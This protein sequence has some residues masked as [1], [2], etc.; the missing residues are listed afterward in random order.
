MS[1]GISTGKRRASGETTANA[2]AEEVTEELTSLPDVE[3]P[4]ERQTQWRTPGFSRMRMTWRPEDRVVI[5]QARQMV[6]G[7]VMRAFADLYRV[8]HELY[9]VVREPEVN[10]DGEALLDDYGLKVWK[11]NEVGHY[12]EDW[13]RLTRREKERFLFV[14]TTSLFDWQSRAG[15][16]WLE[17]MLAKSQFTERFAIAFDA[18]M[19]GTVDDRTS[20]AQVD[21]SEERNFAIL[22]SAYSRKVD[23]LIRTVELLGNRIKDSLA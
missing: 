23:S 16:A 1:K 9:D 5:E 19:S 4:E 7:M 15:D 10:D 20:V 21:A 14:F 8:L 12:V 3:L 2:V 18:P 22:M 13:S 17:A 6:D 11:R